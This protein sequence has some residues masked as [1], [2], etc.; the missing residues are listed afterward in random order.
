MKQ[1]EF[2]ALNANE[3][4]ALGE[5][6]VA[7]VKPMRSEDV[8]RVFPEIEAL[9]PGMK[10]FALLSASGQPIMLADSESTAIANAWENDLSTVTLQ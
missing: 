7:Y 2:K 1:I 8:A 9:Q 6:A 10:L 5:G 3:F 4:A